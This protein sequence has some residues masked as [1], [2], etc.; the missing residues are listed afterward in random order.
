M[1]LILLAFLSAALN[2]VTLLAGPNSPDE[3][4]SIF[5]EY[6]HNSVHVN[7]TLNCTYEKTCF[8]ASQPGMKPTWR[9][10]LVP[11]RRPNG[12]ATVS[13][14]AFENGRHE[15]KATFQLRVGGDSSTILVEKSES[16][17]H[18]VTLAALAPNQVQGSR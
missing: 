12:F 10:E 5:V 7:E 8:L 3:L 13:E 18:E 11:H 17:R 15:Q 9:I 6:R 2:T 1:K 14:K 16:D 4:V